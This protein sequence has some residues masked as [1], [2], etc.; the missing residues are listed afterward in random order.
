MNIEKYNTIVFDCDGVI[1]NSNKIKTEAFYKSALPYGAQAAEA[2]VEYHISNG[3]I[4]RYR[5]FKWLLENIVPENEGP[6]LD[7]L[8]K[9]Y[10][11]E[12]KCGLLTCDVAEGIYE[13]RKKTIKLNWL[14]ASGGDQIEL[15]EIFLSRGLEQLFNGGIFGSPDNKDI[16][17]KREIV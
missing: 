7:T 8:L 2:L 12:V 17:L 10:S 1:L 5:K 3:G 15:R 6:D 4:S 16:I 14:V 13:L 9:T 11:K